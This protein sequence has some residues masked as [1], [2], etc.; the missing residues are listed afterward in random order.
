MKLIFIFLAYGALLQAGSIEDAE[1]YHRHSTMQWN[2]AIQA[3]ERMPAFRNERVLDIGCGDGKITAFLA[4]R[5][6]KGSIL[7]MDISQSMIDFASAHY[8]SCEYPRLGFVRGSATEIPFKGRFDRVVS[9]SA[10]HWVLDQETAYR[11][12]YEALVPG[13]SLSLHVYG[14]APM[15]VVN[16]AETLIHSEKWACQFLS[17]EKQRVFLKKEKLKNLLEGV[18]FQRVEIVEFEGDTAFPDR[19][20]L[21]GFLR[22]VLA[23]A[24]HLPENRKQEFIEEI[25]DRIAFI[26]GST[27]DGLVH[28]RTLNFIALGVKM[29]FSTD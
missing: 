26:S 20:S 16:V 1:S 23:F 11:E 2:V 14:D 24:N 10:M 4:A 28:F 17:Y 25:A 6:E 18:G 3:I 13:G 15:N 9:F 22:P 29:P 27:E 7:G 21:I 12:I 19:A 5:M 8:G